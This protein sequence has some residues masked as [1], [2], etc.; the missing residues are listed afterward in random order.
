MTTANEIKIQTFKNCIG[1][2]WISRA[3]SPL[4]ERRNPSDR[5]DIIGLVPAGSP[6]EVDA[7]VNAAA[8]VVR[9][10]SVTP[11][12]ER[13]DL[14][15]SAARLLADRSTMFARI[16]TREQGKTC[17]EAEGEVKFAVAILEYMAAEGRRLSGQCLPSGERDRFIYT[18]RQ[19]VG[20]VGLITPWNF[21]LAVPLWKIGPALVCGNT[22]VWKASRLTPLTSAAI[23]E[24]LTDA[25]MPAGLVNLVNGA[26][27]IAGT[28][29]T[30]HPAVRAISFTASHQV[31][32]LINAR[33]SKHFKKVQCEAAGKNA[34]IV[35]E[36]ADLDWTAECIVNGAF[37]YAGQRCTATGRVVVVER[38]ANR[39]LDRIIDRARLIK[40][41]NAKHPDVTM[42]PVCDEKQL[43]RVL[44]L[45]EAGKREGVVKWGGRRLEGPEYDR[46]LFIEPTVIDRV[47]PSAIVAQEEVFGPV[48]PVIRTK[49]DD[50][51]IDVANASS[52][53]MTCAVFSCDPDRLS[54]AAEQLACGTVHLNCPT[55]GAEVHAP[56]GGI[57]NSGLGDRE[58]GCEASKF[59]SELKVVYMNRRPRPKSTN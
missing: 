25:G 29:L 14:L 56:F 16:I 50:E 44:T 30:E 20:I 39:L 13:G 34:A 17:L 48:L 2:E 55:I 47:S 9:A 41:G 53:G 15:L 24:L 23:M 46:G 31:A 59:Y 7:A 45:I 43:M 52:Y 36:D 54:G 19:P 27:A 32:Q 12:P 8:A 5:D 10:W 33:A 22:V 3:S 38:V 4:Y 11:A 35:L 40:T 6:D 51:A 1:G 28:A 58:M 49:N 26:G 42:G 18:M 37:G 57:K 21:P